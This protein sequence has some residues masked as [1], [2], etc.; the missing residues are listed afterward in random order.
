MIQLAD[1]EGPDQTAWIGRLIWAFAV[2]ISP[3]T[4][5]PMVQPV[6]FICIV[7]ARFLLLTYEFF[8]LNANLDQ[9]LHSVASDLGLHCSLEVGLIGL[10]N[11][12]FQRHI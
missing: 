8:V 3:K 11:D 1:S 5:F 2:C 10:G 9:M 12:F 4:R 7:L 6:F